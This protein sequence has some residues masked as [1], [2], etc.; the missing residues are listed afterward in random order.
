MQKISKNGIV[1]YKSDILSCPNG[2]STRYGGYSKAPLVN[3]LN[4]TVTQRKGESVEN[5][6][7]NLELFTSA[8]GIDHKTVLSVP[9]CNGTN[10]A[11]VSKEDVGKGYYHNIGLQYFLNGN[12][13]FDGYIAKELGITIGMKT[14]DCLPILFS[15]KDKNGKVVLVGGAHVGGKDDG[16]NSV[17]NVATIVPKLLDEIFIQSNCEA[18]D[19]YVAFGPCAHSCCCKVSDYVIDL[20]SESISAKTLNKYT[21]KCEDNLW[22]MDM[23]GINREILLERGVLAENIDLANICTV[24]SPSDMFFSRIRDGNKT[25]SMLSVISLPEE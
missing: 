17:C 22:S 19:I 8:I 25:G 3:G 24:C 23:V 16:E 2:F 18:K 6:L 14:A 20:L 10:I 9:E 7:K 4:L 1:V 12:V 13:C 21:K 11:I 15:V 5:V